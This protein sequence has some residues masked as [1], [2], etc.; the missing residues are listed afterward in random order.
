MLLALAL[1]VAACGGDDD[2]GDEGDAA[3]TT[4]S[5][6]GTTAG[7]DG[8][9]ASLDDLIA[10]AQEEGSVV[11]YSSPHENVAGALAEAFEAEYGVSAEFVR[12]SSEPL[13][14]R[15]SAEAASGTFAAD[16][17]FTGPSIESFMAEGAESGWVQPISE[18]GIPVLEDGTFPEEFDNG[19]SV[20][21]TVSPWLIPYNTDLVT[22][23]DIPETWEDLVDPRF[24]GRILLP[25]MAPIYLPIFSLLLDEYGE[26]YFEQ[27]RGQD[28]RLT[29]SGTPII[30]SLGAGEA[31]LAPPAIGSQV[32]GIAEEGAPLGT[33]TP[34]LTTGVEFQ[35]V[36][37][38]PDEAA[39]PNAARLFAHF[40]LSEEGNAIAADFP[41][42]FSVYDVSGLP[43]DYRSPEEGIDMEQ[44][45]ELL[46]L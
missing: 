29:G 43:A 13:L 24:E 17:L 40:V 7:A 10:A 27:L 23:D 38:H 21:L 2:G 36:L 32:E 34:D 19:D 46:D 15:Y 18:A 16:V 39:H 8:G 11:F 4:A 41:G 44:L 33:V 9:D 14:Q 20:T 12:L 25:E 1:V 28:L 35:V 3:A 5:G 26:E 45:N 22:G 6:G 37:T 42:T 30:Q 31:D